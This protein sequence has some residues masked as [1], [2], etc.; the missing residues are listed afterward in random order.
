MPDRP[1]QEIRF[2][3]GFI[4]QTYGADERVEAWQL[5]HGGNLRFAPERYQKFVELMIGALAAALEN[6]R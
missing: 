4:I 2:G 5:E 1:E 3:G 6:Q